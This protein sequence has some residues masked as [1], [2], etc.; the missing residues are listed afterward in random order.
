MVDKKGLRRNWRTN[1]LNSVREFAD[2]ETQ[3]RSWLDAANT[4]PHFAFVE[5]LLL[6]R[7]GLSDGDL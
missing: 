4:N 6:L 3:R 7:L 5:C 2:A 1:W